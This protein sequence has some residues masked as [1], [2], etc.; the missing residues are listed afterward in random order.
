M[1]RITSLL[2]AA[3]LVAWAT[4]APAQGVGVTVKL[5]DFD[6]T[7]PDRADY[8]DV[9]AGSG[10]I[11][12]AVGRAWGELSGTALDPVR[13]W[14]AASDRLGKGMTARDIEIRLGTPGAI[15]LTPTGQSK[16][17]LTVA[18]GGNS[19]DLTSTHPVSR[20]KWM[21]PRMR[22]NFDMTLTIDFLM[23]NQAPHVRAT[24]AVLQPGNVRV[25]PLNFAAELGLSIDDVI[26]S[27]GGTQ[28]VENRVRDAFAAARVPVTGSFN[29]QLRSQAGLLALPKDYL[30]NG[31]RVEPGRIVIAGYKPKPATGARVAVVATWPKDLGTLMDDC[32]PVGIGA[33][34]QSGPRPFS[35]AGEAPSATAQMQNMNPRTERSA[36]YACS[37]VLIVPQGAPVSITWADPVRVAA[38]SPNPMVMKTVIAARPSG[39][40]NPIV[41]KQPDYALTLARE[42]RAG[43]G[44]QVDAAVQA[45]R[46]PLDP[47]TGAKLTERVNPAIQTPA[48]RGVPAAAVVSPAA[49][50]ASKVQA[51]PAVGQVRSQ[52]GGAAALNPQPLPPKSAS[53]ATTLRSQPGAAVSLN[54]QPLPP[55]AALPTTA[56]ATPSQASPAPN[57]QSAPANSLRQA[58]ATSLSR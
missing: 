42:S 4:A 56:I 39:W 6:V 41:P 43:T 10:I 29:G 48:Q 35:G 47:V 8:R 18:I 21:D 32:A 50:V 11:D 7:Q 55:K 49:N 57:V 37:V 1:N 20:G 44:L 5:L 31:A 36:G 58:P 23:V 34:W 33:R 14:L 25:S 3:T 30:F 45:R 2:A 17:R 53:G 38:G 28:S 40:T 13:Q 52:P 16:G 24:E 46:S 19:I 12:M 15:R 26:S 9:N 51:A 54:P 22:V 27:L